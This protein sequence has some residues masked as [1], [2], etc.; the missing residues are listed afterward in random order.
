MLWP[1]HCVQGSHGAE[2]HPKVQE[3]KPDVII[4]KGMD[5]GTD[6]YSGFFDNH[7]QHNTG[8]EEWLKRHKIKS[9]WVAGLATDY[10]VKNT[11]LD[12]IRQGFEVTVLEDGIRAVSKDT[13]R[14]AIEDMKKAGARLV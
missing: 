4:R 2:L 1:D 10:C 5:P 6:S 3:W 12:A 14:V 13:G 9:L 11:V 8:L 7:R